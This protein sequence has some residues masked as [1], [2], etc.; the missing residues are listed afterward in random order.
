MKSRTLTRLRWQVYLPKISR[1]YHEKPHTDATALLTIV[2][3][4]LKRALGQRQL[5]RPAIVLSQN[6]AEWEV[7][8][9]VSQA[10]AEWEVLSAVLPAI[11]EWEVLSA[12]SQAIAEWE[13]LSA[14]SPAAVVADPTSS[15]RRD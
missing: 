7:L 9:A 8:S 10:I 4:G 3:G 13:A 11:A 12:V 6:I 2:R 1:K 14:V 5:I 15:S